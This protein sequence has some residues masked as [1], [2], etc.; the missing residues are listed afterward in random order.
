MSSRTRNFFLS[1][2][3]LT[4]TA[5]IIRGVSVAFNIYVSSVAGA[6]AMGLFSLISSVYGFF[7]TIACSSINLGTTRLISEAIAD[8]KS[9]TLH[10]SLS[11]CIRHALIT[12]FLASVILYSLSGFIGRE[13]LY[14]ERCILSL[15]A[16]S[17][18]LLPI[19][20]TSC[21]SGYFTAVRRVKVNA[22]FQ[23]I[24]QAIKIFATAALLSR[25]LEF[26]AEYACLC[27]VLGSVISEIISLTVNVILY[28]LD[29]RKHFGLI[30]TPKAK[31]HGDGI[32]KKICKITFP[33][34]FSA[35][36]R[37]L[38]NTLQHILI[39]RGLKMSGSSWA[40]ALSS[41]GILHSMVLP[42]ILFPS[43]F[44]YSFA[45]L[46]IP[47]VSECRVQGNS[48]RL[49]RI[50]RRVM[51]IATF[52]A[53][54]VAGVMLILSGDIGEVIYDN[55]EAAFYI[56]ILAPLIPVM[57]VDGA[58]DAILKGMGKQ[59]YSMNVNIADAALSC[60]LVFF[61]VPRLGLLGY[62]ISIYATEILNTTLSLIGMFCA[63][64]A[65]PKVVHQVLSP[66]L[67]MTLT[68]II[69]KVILD[70][71]N[72]PFSPTVELIIH[73]ILISIIYVVMLLFTKT[74]GSEENEVIYYSFKK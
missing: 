44:I 5:L 2:L 1:G 31:K 20:L 15:K 38:F 67:C 30:N 48:A 13:L 71:I 43:A 23:I 24:S 59:I 62:I 41:Y 56:K 16:V 33:V 65:K 57:Y 25:F 28:L 58:T 32:V 4:A 3:V 68:W 64:G 46:L 7:I 11:V 42:L 54:G 51:S 45:S 53:I 21:L 6:E 19:S 63:T 35:C 47:E 55:R 50:T 9:N 29:K 14:D 69:S 72:H 40:A 36:I 17:F 61:L 49:E 12:G 39:P 74:I 10:K 18:S 37:S 70:N 22:V 73:I 27:L 26:G 34:T 66:L 60:V 52:F 8:G